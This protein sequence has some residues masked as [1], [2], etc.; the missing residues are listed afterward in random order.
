MSIGPGLVLVLAMAMRACAEPHLKYM[1]F[2]G[3][4]VSAQADWLTLAIT[5]SPMVVDE[6]YTTGKIPSLLTVPAGVFHRGVG[7]APGWNKILTVFAETLVRPRMA[8]KTVLGAFLGDEIC[9]HN[10]S[11]YAAGLEP[12]AARLKEL[13]GPSALVWLWLGVGPRGCF[14]C[15]GAWPRLSAAARKP[16]LKL[17]PPWPLPCSSAPA[18]C[19]IHLGPLP[20]LCADAEPLAL[21]VYTNECSSVD[22]TGVSAL[23]PSL[24][25]FSVDIYAGYTP[26]TEGTAEVV[27]AKAFYEKNV[28][29]RLAPSQR[30]MLVPGTFACSN[31]TF[32]PLAESTKNVVAKLNAYL[33]WAKQDQRIA[34]GPA[35]PPVCVAQLTRVC[36]S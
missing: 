35:A 14:G 15:P 12:V 10:T 23:P 13:L 9:C 22:M 36:A 28:F 7:L 6:F 2:Y 4:N 3:T 34:C 17:P 30:V 29:P 19:P 5:P 11:C 8:N 1:S 32:M 33:V 20:V 16:P 26:N 24:D 25:L 18:L 31:V 27:A 21:Q